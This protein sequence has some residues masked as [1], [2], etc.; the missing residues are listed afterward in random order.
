MP[1]NLQLPGGV[2]L[3]R[4]DEQVVGLARRDE[5]VDQ[6]SRVPEVHVLVDQTVN[7]HQLPL[8]LRGVRQHA[9]LSVSP[10]GGGRKK[11]EDK[12][13]HETHTEATR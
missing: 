10:G 6:P 8:Q 13:V 2:A 12:R 5:R 11:S 1:T 7:Q 4:E 3:V 9:G